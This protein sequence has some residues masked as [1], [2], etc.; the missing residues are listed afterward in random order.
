MVRCRNAESSTISSG[1]PP[2]LHFTSTKPVSYQWAQVRVGFKQQGTKVYAC[3]GAQSRRSL[4]L[5]PAGRSCT[6]GGAL[7]PAW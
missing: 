3:D 5:D 7:Y 4:D 2:V 6:S 1:R